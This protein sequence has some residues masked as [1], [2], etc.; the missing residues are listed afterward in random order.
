[1]KDF[2]IMVYA[3]NNLK[4]RE[5]KVV[6]VTHGMTLTEFRRRCSEELDLDI[7]SIFTRT[8]QRITDILDLEEAEEVFAFE[9]FYPSQYFCS[10][11]NSSATLTNNEERGTRVTNDTSEKRRLRL[12]IETFGPQRAGKTSLIWRFVKNDMFNGDNTEIIE[13][14]F[15][16]EIDVCETTV[17]LTINDIKEDDTPKKFNDRVFQKDVLMF[18]VPVTELTNLMD[19]VIALKSQARK[20]SPSAFQVLVITKC[21]LRPGQRILTDKLAETTGMFVV[22]SSMYD[23]QISGDTMSSEEIFCEIAAECISKSTGKQRTTRKHKD[24]QRKLGSTK[25]RNETPWFMKSLRGLIS[26]FNTQ[27]TSNR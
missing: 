17:H 8:P 5:P 13:A 1:M 23:N 19:W 6:L 12:R 14:T 22:N 16:K 10:S 18:C 3:P 21:D 24:S 27:S 15:E 20:L 26:C 2:K 4:N 9:S 7:L 25:L 11:L